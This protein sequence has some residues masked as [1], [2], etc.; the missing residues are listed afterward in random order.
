MEGFPP[1]VAWSECV[2]AL[3]ETDAIAG[4]ERKLFAEEARAAYAASM[5]ASG[6]PVGLIDAWQRDVVAMSEKLRAE[7]LRRIEA[8]LH[9]HEAECLRH[10]A[11][12][13]LRAQ[14]GYQDATRRLLA[15]RLKVDGE[16]EVQW[17]LRVDR[18]IAF[19]VW[20]WGRLG[21]AQR[22][23]KLYMTKAD[24][25]QAA[26]A[27]RKLRALLAGKLNAPETARWVELADHDLT[28]LES[29]L[30]ALSEQ[31]DAIAGAAARA[32]KDDG[33]AVLREV[34]ARVGRIRPEV[35]DAAV[36]PLVA[37]SVLSIVG[38]SLHRSRIAE[39]LNR[40][41]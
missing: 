25:A 24:A 23:G 36:L 19:A 40:A 37:E 9:E 8:R 38:E 39:A 6:Q 2:Q 4:H 12:A 21:S 1:E 34:V 13:W 17:Q 32:P 16:P 15:V 30:R 28:N 26:R 5:K 33:T 10:D 27:A 7:A 3:A 41:G 18:R 20:S 35:T 22:R 31:L 29:T 11:L 14:S